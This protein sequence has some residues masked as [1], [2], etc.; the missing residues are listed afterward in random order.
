LDSRRD[1]SL[2]LSMGERP[3]YLGVDLRPD[4]DELREG[5]AMLSEALMEAE[6]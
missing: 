2:R 3:S 6:V 5:D 1:K 4:G